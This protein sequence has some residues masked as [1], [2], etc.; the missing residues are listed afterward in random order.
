MIENNNISGFTE[1]DSSS[2]QNPSSHYNNLGFKRQ[3]TEIL[4]PQMKML[5]PCESDRDGTVKYNLTEKST[6]GKRQGKGARPVKGR[7]VD[8]SDMTGE[9]RDDDE[10]RRYAV[11][12]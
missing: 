10:E 4:S 9:K 5:S 1:R 8:R 6:P 7:D 2:L 3:G 12:D 11:P